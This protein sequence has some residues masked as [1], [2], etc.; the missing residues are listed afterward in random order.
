MEELIIYQ[1][2]YDMLKYGYICLREFPK[3]E[4]YALAND[5]KI[6]MDQL[7]HL[8]I[9]ANKRY[10]KKNTLQNMDIELASLKTYIRLAKDLEFLSFKKYENWIKMLDEIGK[11]I[12]GW[13]KS[14]N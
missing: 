4:K 12:G 5:I 7:L 14:I 10:Y 6:I 8:I 3:S 1:K 13:I 2:T 9:Q 11:M